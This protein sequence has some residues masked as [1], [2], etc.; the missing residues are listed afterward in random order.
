MYA[1]AN[2]G[3]TLAIGHERSRVNTALAVE[4]RRRITHYLTDTPQGYSSGSA[5]EFPALATAFCLAVRRWLLTTDAFPN[6]EA[7]R[8]V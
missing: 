1:I 8:S 2:T 6:L 3:A 5:S 7:G 4:P